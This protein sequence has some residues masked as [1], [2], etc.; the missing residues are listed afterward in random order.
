MVKMILS[1]MPFTFLSVTIGAFSLPLQNNNN[2]DDEKSEQSR[3]NDIIIDGT[4][5]LIYFTCFVVC[6]A[7]AI[8]NFKKFP[9]SVNKA[10]IVIVVLLLC[11]LLNR[12]LCL[13]YSIFFD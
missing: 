7:I 2:T 12:L 6:L 4:F 10:N 3:R 5:S 13:L 11:T 8:K 9:E 1:Y